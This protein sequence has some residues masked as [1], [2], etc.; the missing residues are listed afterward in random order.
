[1][2]LQ[3][4]FPGLS[5]EQ[6]DVIERISHRRSCASGE[7]ILHQG[8]VPDR[9]FVMLSGTARVT[10]KRSESID[11]EFTGPLGPGDL[12]GEF[13]FVDGAAASATITAD[14]EVDLIE[15]DGGKLHAALDTDS[16]L[17]AAVFKSLL[18]T[19]VR[20]LRNTNMRIVTPSDFE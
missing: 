20:R 14:G 12:F 3:R 19:V 4:T 15:I 10:L 17:A 7:N 13:S 1:M 6:I 2:V 5:K 9:L 16:G 11:A 8:D 18:A